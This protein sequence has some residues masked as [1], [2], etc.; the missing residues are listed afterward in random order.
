M[1]TTTLEPNN[2]LS[3]A[4]T[5]SGS[6]YHALASLI[7]QIA[8]EQRD[9]DTTTKASVAHWVA[10]TRPKRRTAGYLAQALS[11]KVGRLLTL[12]D[13]GLASEEHQIF[14]QDRLPTD[15]VAALATLGRFDVDRRTMIT[16]TA[17]SIGALLLPLHQ[18]EEHAART[19]RA[20]LLPSAVGAAEIDAV[21]TM[22]KAFT[23]ADEKLGG[24]HARTAVGEYLATDVVTYLSGKF[25][26]DYSRK[27]MFGAASSVAYLAG[28]KAHDLG[29][30]GLAQ[31][32]YLRSFQ[33]AAESDPYA[34]AGYTLR[35]LAHQAMDLGRHEHCLDLADEALARTKGRVG[36][37]VESLFWLTTARANAAA[38]NPRQARDALRQAEKRINRAR[39]DRGPSWAA[40]GGPA[41]ARLAHQSG[42]TLQAIG[43]LAEAEEQ[44]RRAARYWSPVTHPRVY[45]LTLADLAETQCRRGHVEAACA[46][47]TKALANMTGIRSART[48]DAVL[49]LRQHLAPYKRRGLDAA[50]RLD[51]HAARML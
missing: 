46:T 3:K 47:W 18:L 31:Q 36:A 30:A 43:D 42:K 51:A 32:Y 25:K 10:G 12:A 33:L 34:H 45:A 7:Q 24:A 40:L 9:T 44:H 48:R 22:T 11:R 8:R 5:E 23:A 4:I 13:I 21:R 41:A 6:S 28:W 37:G 2:A 19:R 15:P 50:R 35:I 14:D 38:G 17:Y 1:R 26:S 49:S 27:A 39:A 20:A 16:S 29:M